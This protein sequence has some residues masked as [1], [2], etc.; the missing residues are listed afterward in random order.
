MEETVSVDAAQG[1]GDLTGDVAH[2]MFFETAAL[3]LALV[4]EFEQVAVDVL[5]DQVG[6]VDDAHQLLELDDVGVCDLAQGL[7]F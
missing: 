4:D 5:E 2:L 6:V 1:L 7:D 3:L